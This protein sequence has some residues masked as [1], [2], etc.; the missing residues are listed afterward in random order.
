MIRYRFLKNPDEKTVDQLIA[1]YTAQGWWQ[2]GDTRALLRRMVRGSRR[3]IAAFEGGRLAGMARAIDAF[4]N[5]AYIHD[6]TV[7]REFRGRGVGSGLMRRLVA[8]L[9]KDGMVWVGLISADGSAP[10]YRALGF[11]IPARSAAMMKN[12]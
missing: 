4:S 7:A 10:F 3:F 9:K 6:V 1:L 8:R 11:K 2:E 5:E 12:V